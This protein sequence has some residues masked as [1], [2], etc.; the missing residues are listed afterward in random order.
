MI[1]PSQ[2]KLI[3]TEDEVQ[4][5]IGYKGLHAFHKYWGKKPLEP[6]VYLIDKLTESSGLVI[7][8]FMGSCASGLA[9]LRHKRRFIGID[10]NPIA[11]QLAATLLSPPPTLD[12]KEALMYIERKAKKVILDSYYS[13]SS[14]AP[15]THYLWQNSKLI[16]MWVAKRH[17]KGRQEY[18]PTR[19][20]VTICK[21]FDN[22]KPKRIRQPHFFDNSRI[23]SKPNFTLHDLFTG[24][25]LRNVEILLDAISDLPINQQLPMKLA[26]TASV[27]QMSK[28]VFAITGRGKTSGIASEKIEV[29][30]WIIGYW[31]PELHFEINVWNC[32]EGRT[33]RFITA[34]SQLKSNSTSEKKGSILEV[35]KAY[36]NYSLECGDAI[37]VLENIPDSSADLILTDPPHGDRIPYLELSE[38]WNSILGL[39]ANFSQEIVVSNAKERGKTLDDY[40]AKM[41]RFIEIA[42]SKI[43]SDGAMVV[44]FNARDSSSWEFLS[45]FEAITEKA[46]ISY[47]GHFCV[48]YSAGSVVQDNRKGALKHDYALVFSNS[49]AKH[50]KNL[51][52]LPGWSSTMPTIG[53]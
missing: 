3:P 50:K 29:G 51:K 18:K 21:Q 6:L 30:S 47:L 5:P 41:K 42:V 2:L 36:S 24:R 8:P 26:L 16:Q 31:R 22:Y 40:N 9:A 28:M 39:D 46:N 15:I 38:L 14:D 13:P 12:I 43:K 52:T 25:A 53:I 20:D 11:V 44:L 27:G 4:S 33:K 37:K 34:L 32:F 49:Q 19:D 17:S 48:N 35:V 7:D 23:N 1:T 45:N 10:L